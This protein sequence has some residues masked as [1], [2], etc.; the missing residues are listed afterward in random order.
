[1]KRVIA[2]LYLTLISLI[3]IS[4]CTGDVSYTLSVPPNADNTYPPGTVVELCITMDGW[5]GNAQGSNWF[6]GFYIAL[7]GGWQTVT[8]TLYPEDAEDV[9]GTWIWATSTT[10]ANGATAG[11]GFYFEGPT[12]PVDGNGGN[13]W[14]DSCPSQTCIW[15]CCVELVAANGPSG[16]DLLIGVIP[17][18][19]GTM[20]SWGTQMCNEVQTVLFSGSIGCTTCG[21]TDVAACNYDPAVCCDDG[22][23]GYFTMGD[24]THNLMPCPDT[25]CV[26]S[27]VNYSVTGDQSS[28]YDWLLNTGGLM[29]TDHTN[30]CSV[31][32]SNIPGS[33]QISV[34]ETT[35]NGCV[36]DIV[37]CDI[38]VIAPDI[39]FDSSY[40]ICYNQTAELNASPIG[41]TWSGDY[42][43]GNI[44][45]GYEPGLHL[46]TYS[47]VIHGCNYEEDTQIIV[48]PLYQAPS[49]IYSSLDLDLCSDIVNQVYTAVDDRSSTYTW[50]VDGTIMPANNSLSLEFENI[51]STYLIEVHG[52][53]NNG[54]ASDTAS[55]NVLANACQ[56]LY[57]PNTFTPNGDDV[58]DVFAVKGLGVYDVDLS[59]F[60]RW[61]NM[62]FQTNS[63]SNPWI[64]NCNGGSYYCECGV[65]QWRMKYRDEKG[66]NQNKQG[67]VTLIR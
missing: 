42:V 35:E 24:I 21:C 6:E 48:E 29:Q 4:Q 46:V 54:C 62:V 9:S 63:L 20:G 7:G 64:G 39:I 28:F 38:E 11:N 37:T 19:D 3:G 14:G 30:D 31:T 1:M 18:S 12:G 44:F 50:A 58:N 67:Y 51:T 66:F 25:V 65:Y 23:C 13:D 59:V 36:G 10:S 60:D 26:G 41:G 53:D 17:Y 2:T 43:N 56:R 45:I 32:W 16:L 33:Y 8:P 55:I 22:S 57:V 52:T 27:Q 49:I 47:T 5:Q 34:Q 61:G 15:S 40:R